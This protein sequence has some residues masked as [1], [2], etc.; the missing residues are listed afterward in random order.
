M[1]HLRRATRMTNLLTNVVTGRKFQPE[2]TRGP[3]I[4]PH[5]N[6]RKVEVILGDRGQCAANEFRC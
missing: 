3:T 6:T 2:D 5:S 1:A 4:A